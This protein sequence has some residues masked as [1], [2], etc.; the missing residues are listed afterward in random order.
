MAV[1]DVG[2]REERAVA[3][4]AL[5]ACPAFGTHNKNRRGGGDR[6]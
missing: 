6:I 5:A 2:G 1:I 3:G 4:S